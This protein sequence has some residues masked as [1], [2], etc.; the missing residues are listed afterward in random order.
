VHNTEVGVKDLLARYNYSIEQ[1]AYDGS[2]EPHGWYY[3]RAL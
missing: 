3:A 2:P 1:E